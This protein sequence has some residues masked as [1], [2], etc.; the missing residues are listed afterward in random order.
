VKHLEKR[1]EDRTHR[2]ELRRDVERAGDAAVTALMRSE[3]AVYRMEL[4]NGRLRLRGL[5]GVTARPQLQ[6]K[7]GAA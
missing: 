7:R 1:L 6:G 3:D 2:V 5:K 4:D